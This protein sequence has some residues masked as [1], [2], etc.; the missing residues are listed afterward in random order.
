[1]FLN[2]IFNIESLNP[3]E[4]FLRSMP[5]KVYITS[6]KGKGM[7]GAFYRIKRMAILKRMKSAITIQQREEHTILFLGKTTGEE[8]DLAI[9]YQ[10]TVHQKRSVLFVPAKTFIEHELF[11]Y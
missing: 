7:W 3:F 1:M 11:T 8:H 10:R 6:K 5:I 4:F 2:I 9:V